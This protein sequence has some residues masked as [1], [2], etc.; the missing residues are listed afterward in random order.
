MSVRNILNEKGH[1]VFTMAP[2]ATLQEAARELADRKI[3]AVILTDDNGRIAGIL[4]ERDI[5]RMIARNGAAC[6]DQSISEVMTKKVVTC[7][8]AATL[9]DLMELMTKGRFRHIPVEDHGR[10]VG[11][12][13][14]GDVVKRRIEDA[15]EEAEQMRSYIAA[16]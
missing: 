1:Q 2:G 5:V 12:I 15:L 9:D 16:G 10:L 3:G 11:V 6:L 8:E 4:S 13:S 14:I 7:T